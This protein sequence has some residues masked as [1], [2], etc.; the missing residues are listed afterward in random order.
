MLPAD[1]VQTN[2]PTLEKRTVHK[3]L[4]MV[5]PHLHIFSEKKPE[6]IETLVY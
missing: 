2:S 3:W 4:S 6:M 1:R 5:L